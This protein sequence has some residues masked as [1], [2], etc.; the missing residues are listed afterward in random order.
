M[1]KKGMLLIILLMVVGFAA[2]STTLFINGNTMI[3]A[4]Q[5]DFNVYFSN[6]YVNQKQDKS[7][8]K[9]DTVI[10]FET[11]FNAVGQKYILDYEVTNGSKNYDAELK[12]NCVSSSEYLTVTNDFDD[13]KILPSMDYRSGRLNVELTKSYVGEDLNVKIEC[14]LDVNAV[15]RSSLGIFKEKEIEVEAIDVNNSVLDATAYQISGSARDELYD[16]LIQSNNIEDFT[17]VRSFIQLESDSLS[18]ISTVKFSVSPIATTGDNVAILNF[19]KATSDWE[20]ISLNKVNLNKE[21]IVDFSSIEAI[22]FATQNDDGSLEIKLS[23]ITFNSN[24]GISDESIRSLVY[25]QTIGNLPIP[26]RTGY[27]FN[28]WYTA[29]TGGVKV[30]SNYN[31]KGDITLYA[32]WNVNNYNVSITNN[33]NGTVSTNT[34]NVDYSSTNTFTVTPDNGYYLSSISCTN[35]YT[36]SGFTA[37]ISHLITQTVTVSNNGNLKDSVCTMNFTKLPTPTI[38]GGSNSWKSSNVTV[39]LT[40]KPTLLGNATYE[41]YVTTSTTAP[42]ASTVATGTTTGSVTIS[43]NGTRYVYFRLKANNNSKSTWSSAQKVMLDKT[44]PTVSINSSLP[45]SVT[46]GDSFVLLGNYTAGGPSGGSASCKSNLN[47]TA[48]NTSTLTTVGTHT[49]TCTVTTGA[50]KT[51][52]ATKS[53]KITYTAYTVKNLVSNGSFE[54]GVDGWGNYSSTEINLYNY[55]NA[56]FSKYGNKTLRV[57]SLIDKQTFLRANY[58]S[59]TNLKGHK[60]YAKVSTLREST[61]VNPG[62]YLEFSETSDFWSEPSSSTSDWYSSYNSNKGVWIDLS[63]YNDSAPYNYFKIMLAQAFGTNVVNSVFHF[64]GLI[65]VDLTATFGSGNEPNKAWCDKYITYFDGS[66]TIYK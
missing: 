59:V 41:Y 44:T 27:E 63:I 54:T 36:V 60:I 42:S 53:I 1:R 17:S 24:G 57:Q 8:I 10:E 40:N 3:S 33:G 62:I 56:N 66:K 47:G 43:D 49:I 2:V 14:T 45:S 50:G 5:D 35:G 64:D 22:P 26:T 23:T 7:V 12:M 19:N 20:F 29:L 37:G 21:V 4:N 16:L 28:G 65:V 51:A 48:T 58:S 55:N 34:L 31:V 9:S 52:T 30:D 11:E 61:A 13:E 46:K 15:E 25:N 6:A 32:I 39:S 18:D 38:T